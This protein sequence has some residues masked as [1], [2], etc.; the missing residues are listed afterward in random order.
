MENSRREHQANTDAASNIS[1]AQASP[2]PTDQ[3]ERASTG[4]QGAN[5]ISAFQT[6]HLSLKR[7]IGRYLNSAQ[8]IE[9]VSQEAFVRAFS[10][11]KTTEVRQPKSFL[12]RIAK[13]VAISQLRKK[14]NQITDYIEDQ[15]THDVLV[16]EWS[17]ED[18]VLIHE[19]LDIHSEAVASLPPKCREVYLLRKVY[20]LS[21][22]EIAAKLDI[23]SST[24]E[25]H[26]MKGVEDC[27]RFIEERMARTDEV[28]SRLKVD[29]QTKQSNK[30]W[31]YQGNATK[32]AAEGSQHSTKSSAT[33][34]PSQKPE[35]AGDQS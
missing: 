35:T 24:V 20:G 11:E 25:K 28:K 2:L 9:D 32:P 12:F 8:D 18:E 19:K 10:A 13:N 5:V 22:K 4:N 7:F 16:N 26:L 33:Q 14:S 17:T 30:D 27:D 6:H 3:R 31:Y 29:S 21:H 34:T 1:A 15:P 23:A